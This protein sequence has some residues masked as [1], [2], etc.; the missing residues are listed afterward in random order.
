MF[1]PETIARI[2]QTVARTTGI[3]LPFDVTVA[4]GEG[5]RVTLAHGRAEI[6]AQEE[7]ALARGFF[8]LARCVREGKA[9]LNV[10]QTRHFDAC[11]AMIDVSRGAVLTPE[12]VRRT[13]D[14]LA[15]LGMNALMLYTEDT[16]EVPEYPRLGYLRGRYAQDDLRALDAYAASLGVEMIP[17]IQ[18][19]GHM[20]QFLQ[21][22]DQA[23]L[24]DQPDI[25]MIGEEATYAFIEAE[26]RAMRACVR[27]GRIH[28]G[29]DEAH[30]VGLGTYLL[31]HG[32][33]DRF[34]LLR[35]HL[36][37]VCAICEKYGFRPI[38]WSDMFFRLGS[39]TN[40][41]YDPHA[42]IPQR[43]IDHLPPVD[44]CYWDYYHDD[45]A[46]YDHMLAE[47]ARMGENTLFAGGIWTWSGFLPHVKHTLRTMRP[48]LAA[49]ARHHVK[50]VFATMWGDDAAETNAT[51]G[52]GLLPLFS[53]SCWQGPD[54]AMED[55]WRSGECVTGLPCEALM[56]MGEFYPEGQQVWTGKQL[57]WCDPLYPLAPWPG[58]TLVD[59]VSRAKEALSVLRRYDRLDC[60]YAAALFDVVIAKAA[61]VQDI[62]SAYAAGDKAALQSIAKDAIPPLAKRYQALMRAHRD[63]WERD[64][65]RNGWEVHVLRYGGAIARLWDA[66][67][68]L[69][70]YA[71]GE[72]TTLCELDEAPQSPERG[73]APLYKT[74]VTPAAEL[75]IGL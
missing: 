67:D 12:A 55:V 62:R 11:G 40:D 19:L 56:A 3:E 36:E 27:S 2:R 37:R 22:D 46:L 25:L 33:S 48:A 70:R 59:A 5:L 32:Q 39:K 30:G 65:K 16:Y 10:S 60:R 44:L 64:M 73:G 7:N 58:D 13:L 18:T 47:H 29:M 68:A 17:C 6:A 9:S 69:A 38:M 24:R 50:T 31:K 43:V 61:L 23:S 15:C 35:S 45:P 54:Y 52:Y 42:D 14:T 71:S 49:C 41:Y 63:L 8:L 75:G 51:L 1:A 72:L 57:I 66:Q 4:R 28:I 21:W 26:I 53:E 20:R 74:L 34:E